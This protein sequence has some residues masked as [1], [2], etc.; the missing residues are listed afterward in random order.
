MFGLPDI[1]IFTVGFAVA[2]IV[3]L[4]VLWAFRFREVSGW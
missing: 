4:L 2:L 1:T 3:F